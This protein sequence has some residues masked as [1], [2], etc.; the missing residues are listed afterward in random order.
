[1]TLRDTNI[2]RA[3]DWPHGLR[4][5]ECQVPFREGMPYSERLTGFQDDNPMLLIICVGCAV[6]RKR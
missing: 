1:V 3:V 6:A 5:A 4:C 2:Y